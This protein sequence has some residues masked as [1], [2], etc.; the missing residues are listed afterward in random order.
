MKQY[1]FVALI[2][3]STL[4]SCK[5][6]RPIYTEPSE[7][8]LTQQLKKYAPEGEIA[9]VN[10]DQVIRIE[11]SKGNVFTFPKNAFTKNGKA[12]SGNVQ[13]DITEITTKS[14]MI[15]ADLLTN[16]DEGPL[17]SRGEFNI[18]ATQNGTE[19][20]LADGIEFT[21]ENPTGINSSEMK[22]WY[23][24][25]NKNAGSDEQN[26][27][28]T[29]GDNSISDP[30][31]LLTQLKA[32]LAATDP[33]LETQKVSNLL[34]RIGAVV[35]SKAL[36]EGK[37]NQL[38]LT[39]QGY[40]FNSGNDSWA[41]LDSTQVNQLGILGN[42]DQFWYDS[43]TSISEIHNF[44]GFVNFGVG[45]SYSI[46]YTNSAATVN[47]DP[48]VITVP[49]TKLSFCNIDALIS[50]YGLLSK[51]KITIKDAPVI[52]SVYF[53]FPDVNGV[54]ACVSSKD[55]E[56]S[57][58]ALP[59]GIP[60]QVLVYYKDGDKIQFGIET[61]SASQNMVFDSSKLKTLNTVADLASE[62]EKID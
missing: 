42:N 38:L 41:Y 62:I 33:T 9:T 31:D 2:G 6:P 22:A 1:F 50:Q 20:E 14:E 8:L 16:S 51:C 3:A 36:S 40:T 37:N 17:D 52:A 18:V 12:V 27:E 54:M 45:C 59:N 53:V 58:G 44:S 26:G 55:E 34:S 15:F 30:C 56:F 32:E 60:I 47:L 61:I 28:W 10:S 57:I 21:I 49:F 25:E 11:T 46:Y 5:K 43:D 35:Y 48:N 13:I 39:L 29:A 23:W 24:N 19:L 7:T 4:W